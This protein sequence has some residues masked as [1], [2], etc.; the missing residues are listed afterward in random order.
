MAVNT[1]VLPIG[2]IGGVVPTVSVF[3]V[4]GQEMPVP[5]FKLSPAFGAD[6]SVDFQGLI[7][8]I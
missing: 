1:E 5:V 8:V 4:Y 7:P 2:T 6:Q 3:M